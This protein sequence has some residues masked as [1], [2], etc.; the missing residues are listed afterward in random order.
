MKK[1][2]VLVLIFTSFAIASH[3]QAYEGSIQYN[4]KNQ[5][6]AL[7]DY[8]YSTEAVQNA[9]IKKMEESG[10]KA[11]EEK[12]LFNK[13]K[14]FVI[15]KDAYITEITDNRMDYIVKVERRSRKAT[16]ESIIY[17]ILSKNDQNM[18]DKMDAEAMQRV[19]SFLNNLSP[20]IAAADLALQILAQ[21]AVIAKGEK[22]LKELM[23]DQTNLEKKLTD[24]KADQSKTQKDIENQKQELDILIG[25]R[26]NSN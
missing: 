25:K 12:G 3:A 10:F 4:K 24:N 21:E 17:L 11:T 7:I 6:A 9:I 14:G 15:F 20:D 5:K 2:I 19:K 23:D 1:Y 8:E 26:I 22:R 13:D 16:D 18:L